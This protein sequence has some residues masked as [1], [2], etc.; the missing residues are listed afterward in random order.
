ME[1]F[2]KNHIFKVGDLVQYNDEACLRGTHI[3]VRYQ[4]MRV[5]TAERKFIW[6]VVD[7]PDNRFHNCKW[8]IDSPQFHMLSP[9]VYTNAQAAKFLKQ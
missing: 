3:E 5:I 6:F 7:S 1:G 9:Y 4:R 2:P 8:T